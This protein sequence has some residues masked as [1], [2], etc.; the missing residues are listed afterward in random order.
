MSSLAPFWNRRRGSA[1]HVAGSDTSLASEAS[2]HYQDVKLRDDSLPG[3][4]KARLRGG[5]DVGDYGGVEKE[6]GRA[7]KDPVGQK[8]GARE[9]EVSYSNVTKS[10]LT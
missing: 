9:T 3:G 10:T 6:E 5:E 8:D 2:I 7:E 4:E 1:G